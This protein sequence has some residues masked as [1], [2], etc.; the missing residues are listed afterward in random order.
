MN[1]LEYQYK[2]TCE[3]DC[4]VIETP[5]RNSD[6]SGLMQQDALVAADL[7]TRILA[8]TLS[9]Q[10]KSFRGLRLVLHSGYV[11]AK[12]AGTDGAISGVISSSR[13]SSSSSSS[14][15]SRTSTSSSN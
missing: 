5:F 13:S 7:S 4:F 8:A 11:A 6:V 2:H 14:S 1:E 12:T 9:M 10:L 3:H 15:S